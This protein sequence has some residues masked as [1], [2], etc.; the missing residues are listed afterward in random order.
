MDNTDGGHNTSSSSK[1][2]PS[3][4]ATRKRKRSSRHAQPS[5]SKASTTPAVSAS[6]GDD[7]D[8]DDGEENKR[9]RGNQGNFRGARLKYL[10]ES[11]L[12]Y[13]KA[14]PKGPCLSKIYSQWF[15]KWPW[16]DNNNQPE[17]FDILDSPD[18]T[19]SDE[20][21]TELAD[22]RKMAQEAVQTA[23]K[24]QL[25]RWFWRN[26]RKASSSVPMQHSPLAPLLRKALGFAGGA[27]R[28][29]ILYKV[30]MKRPENRAKVQEAVLARIAEKH[31]E[32]PM[33]LKLRCE[34]AE[35]LFEQ[36]PDDVRNEIEERVE[37]IYE[38]Q[39]E[40]YTKITTGE[41]VSL[42][43][44]GEDKDADEVREICRESLTKFLQP[45]LDLLRLYTGLKFCLLAG[46]PPPTDDD[47]FF[48]LTIN[49]G[50]ST[51]LN[52]Q[53]FQNWHNEYFTKNVMALFMLFLCNQDPK[54]VLPEPG[55]IHP[56]SSKTAATSTSNATTIN[57]PSLIRMS[58]EQPDI[59]TT[60]STNTR[61]QRK[62]SKTT[63][64]RRTRND[65]DDESS[66]DEDTVFRDENGKKVYLRE[67]KGR[68]IETRDQDVVQQHFDA[69]STPEPDKPLPD[70]LKAYLASL[71]TES[72]RDI[73]GMLNSQSGIVRKHNIEVLIRDAKV[74]K[75]KEDVRSPPSPNT[76]T[77]Q[78]QTE[79][80][81]PASPASSH[82]PST[83]AS[84]PPPPH[85]SG[86]IV[87]PPDRQ[88]VL[89]RHTS[90]PLDNMESP[91]NVFQLK[92]HDDRIAAVNKLTS[93]RNQKMP[94]RFSSVPAHPAD[95]NNSDLSWLSALTAHPKT[96]SQPAPIPQSNPPVNT[97]S[98]T[99]RPK[100]RPLP[101]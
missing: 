9:K 18:S 41:P 59:S 7:D 98:N 61:K 40:L 13:V 95:T 26:S 70:V 60:T 58:E 62:K 75:A 14:K 8:D 97:K 19:M 72:R 25:E 81:G 43:E 56:D 68:I 28:R 63:G 80:L 86:T 78:T 53:T 64:R 69:E 67:M 49:S 52:P 48:L 10:Q 34:V 35:S 77:H 92:D 79:P 6:V 32:K 20:A 73:L 17:R 12:E 91:D 30:W 89:V 27:P 47:D 29:T 50:E 100:P 31:V 22:E 24:K 83:V 15:D 4:S 45:L 21:R 36:E 93:N 76:G 16:H 85:S 74:W 5:T 54:G 3:K 99:A 23:G 33:L 2:N 37:E 1:N 38:Q 94:V 44:L 71:L 96:P 90:V 66:D 39:L 51:G 101:Q 82:S 88:S 65:S 42:E 55:L 11:L 57:D 84:D 46:A 87:Q